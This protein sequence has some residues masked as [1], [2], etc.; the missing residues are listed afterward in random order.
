MRS[1]VTE[2]YYDRVSIEICSSEKEHNLSKILAFLRA[3]IPLLCKNWVLS[4]ETESW[5][6]VE[7]KSSIN[8][9]VL[10]KKLPEELISLTMD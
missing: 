4:R 8:T 5:C 9:I 2:L 6:D 3:N 10:V 7:Q 1:E